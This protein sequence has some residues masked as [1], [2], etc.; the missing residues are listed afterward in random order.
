VKDLQRFDREA[1][2]LL[3]TRRPRWFEV[4]Y[5]QWIG[6]KYTPRWDRGG[7]TVTAVHMDWPRLQ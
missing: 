2:C 5:V 6:K 7:S 1:W 3:E 4:T